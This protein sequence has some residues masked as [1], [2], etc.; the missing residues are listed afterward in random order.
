MIA[1]WSTTFPVVGSFVSIAKRCPGSEQSSASLKNATTIFDA[2]RKNP[3]CRSASFIASIP[4]GW[5]EPFTPTCTE[6]AR[7]WANCCAV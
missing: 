7:S 5:R 6:D 1:H 2:S 3:A 4:C